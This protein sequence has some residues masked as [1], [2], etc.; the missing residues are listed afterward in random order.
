MILDR[1][2]NRPRVS[3]N[4]GYGIQKIIDLI[5]PSPISKIKKKTFVGHIQIHHFFDPLMSIKVLVLLSDLT[6]IG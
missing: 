6:K 5:G 3:L 2:S 1:I 4:Q